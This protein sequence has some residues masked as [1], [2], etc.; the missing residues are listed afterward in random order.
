MSLDHNIYYNPYR[1]ESTQYV[2]HYLGTY[3]TFLELQADGFEEHGMYTNPEY[4]D[5]TAAPMSAVDLTI[6]YNSP[7]IGAGKDLNSFFTTDIAGHMRSDW[8]MGAY[9]AQGSG[10][11]T[12]SPSPPGS[13]RL[14]DE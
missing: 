6:R 4:T 1:G 8:D 5:L 11:D 9:E 2:A 3:K 13:V 12:I 10:V 7:A 14:D